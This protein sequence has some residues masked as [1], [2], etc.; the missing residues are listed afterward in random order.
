[1]R[2]TKCQFHIVAR[3]LQLAQ[4]CTNA[5]GATTPPCFVKTYFRCAQFTQE[6]FLKINKVDQ[7]IYQALKPMHTRIVRLK[8]L[9]FSS[10]ILFK[11]LFQYITV[12]VT[13]IKNNMCHNNRN[14]T[15]PKRLH[16]LESMQSHIG[17]VRGTTLEPPLAMVL[18]LL[19]NV[20]CD[21]GAPIMCRHLPS[22]TARVLADLRHDRLALW[23]VGSVCKWLIYHI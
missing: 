6:E 23:W 10:C 2:F 22:Q 4:N 17:E 13:V 15:P 3:F 7:S 16:Y 1:M 18:T 5:G 8:I 21:G 9:P 19:Y 11:L 12:T 20:G 14:L